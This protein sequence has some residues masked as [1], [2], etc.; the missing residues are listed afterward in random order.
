M[1]FLAIFLIGVLI[2]GCI[3]QKKQEPE[4]DIPKY[5][6]EFPVHAGMTTSEVA[7]AL[8]IS[9]VDP[10]QS[11]TQLKGPFQDNAWSGFYTVE[12]RDQVVSRV[13]FSRGNMNVVT[14]C[15]ILS[16]R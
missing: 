11:L 10:S 8:H 2:S 12:F 7:Q 9:W 16:E 6:K 13:T 5:I 3:A 14:G 4:S 1:R 15:W